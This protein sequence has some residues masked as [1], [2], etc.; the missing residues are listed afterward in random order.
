MADFL[1]AD[2]LVCLL[3]TLFHLCGESMPD[4]LIAV[5]FVFVFLCDYDLYGESTPDFAVV[6]ALRV[7]NNRQSVV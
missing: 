4:F 5:L 7:R 6:R 1:F 2:V 3:L